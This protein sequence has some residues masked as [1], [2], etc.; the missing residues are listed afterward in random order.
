L[1]GE[2]WFS[3]CH[4]PVVQLGLVDDLRRMSH[5]RPDPGEDHRL[6]CVVLPDLH[7]LLNQLLSH[8][9][10]LRGE[11][12]VLRFHLFELLPVRSLR[13]FPEDVSGSVIVQGR[14]VYRDVMTVSCRHVM[15]WGGG[16]PPHHTQR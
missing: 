1:L 11:V 14:V 13:Q 4:H 3:K 6:L 12:C 16:P 10:N 7:T 8:G 9:I 2:S 5:H 15:S